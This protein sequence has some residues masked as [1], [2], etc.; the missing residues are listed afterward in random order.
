MTQQNQPVGPHVIADPSSQPIGR[1]VQVDQPIP[2]TTQVPATTNIP[3]QQQTHLV[4]HAPLFGNDGRITRAGIERTIRNGGS[5]LFGGTAISSLD[6]I[7]TD[8]QIAAFYAQNAQQNATLV[9]DGGKRG[10]FNQAE[11][12]AAQAALNAANA[13]IPAA[14]AS[15]AA[16]IDQQIAALQAQKSALPQQQAEPAQKGG[17]AK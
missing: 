11:I 12:D 4:G 8:A 7:P 10:L 9:Q 13:A 14:Q 15:T 16:S 5:V 2:S 3:Q 6:K 1:N 17:K